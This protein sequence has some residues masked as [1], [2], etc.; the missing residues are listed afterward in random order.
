MITLFLCMAFLLCI[1]TEG[2]FRKENY[3]PGQVTGAVTNVPDSNYPGSDA[4][5]KRDDAGRDDPDG[6]NT[7]TGIP[8]NRGSEEG[9]AD[10]AEN[11]MPVHLKAEPIPE[12]PDGGW[13]TEAVFPDRKGYVD[14][15]LAM[16]SMI[17]FNGRSGQGY[18]YMSL[19]E[20]VQSLHLFVNGHEVD[21]SGL[22]GGSSCRIDFSEIAGNGN[23]TIQITQIMPYD[24]KEAVSIF[25]PYPTVIDG[26]PE[27]SGIRAETVKLIDDLISSDIEYG[28]PGAQLAV[29]RHGRLVLERSWGKVNAYLPD[30]KPNEESAYVTADTMYDLASVTKMFSVNYALQKLLTEGRYS[31]DDK[32]SKYLG[33]RFFQDVEDIEYIGGANPGIRTQREWKAGITIRDLLCHQAGFP[34]SINYPNPYYSVE[35]LKNDKDS[36]NVLYSGAGAD[37]KTKE[38]TI[39]AMCRTPL[40]Y[41]PRTATKYSDIDYMLLGVIVEELAGTDLDSYLKE[42]FFEPMELGHITYNP[43]D[44]GFKPEDCAATE[45]NGNTRD[46]VMDFPGIRTGTLQG[47]VHDEKAWYCMGGISGHAGLFANATDLAK[48]ASVMLTGGYGENRF[49]SKN[50]MDLF[51]APKSVEFGQWGLGWWRN[52][53][54]QRPWYFGS[55]AGPDV[56]GHQGWT[57]TLVMIDPDR[58]LVIVYL[59][60]KINTPVTNKKAN[61]NRFDGNWYT[62]STLG[63]VPQILSIGM[64]DDTDIMPQL[65]SL[66][67]DMANESRKLIHANASSGHPAVKNHESKEAVLRKR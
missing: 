41:E 62:A 51:T 16:N 17:G 54:D 59:T 28:F 5:D 25:V 48:L 10:T 24:L 27:E 57:G 61:P 2:C 64:D 9:A 36:E 21:T 8:G 11:E 33:D 26:D 29:I 37:E 35:K 40:L 34:D 14:D 63:F 60:N 42:N 66:V 6:E 49:F 32:V 44:N 31:L 13:Q 56:I 4:G 53:D 67:A 3:D 39:E 47:Q 38:A 50:V 30:G 55:D 58:D 19:N 7:V 15:T 20:D 46:G 45:L 65:R 18:F 43:L 22:K 12:I 1:G 23:N 52:G